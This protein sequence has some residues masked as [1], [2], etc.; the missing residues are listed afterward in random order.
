MSSVFSRV[1][2]AVTLNATLAQGFSDAQQT[3]APAAGGPIKVGSTA[4]DKP[5]P[6]TVNCTSNATTGALVCTVSQLLIAQDSQRLVGATIFRPA[7]AAGAVMRLSLPHGILLQK[8]IDLGIDDAAPVNHPIVIA[9]QN[10]SYSD[11]PLD[12]GMLI[13][14]QAG[15]FLHVGVTAGSG[16]KVEFQLSLKSFTA[17]FAK[18]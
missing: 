14:L 11:V 8:G 7:P 18:L 12:G 3:A 10:G 9:D 1:V 13:K 15:N 4:N 5:Q 2:L 17:A 16:E 6:W